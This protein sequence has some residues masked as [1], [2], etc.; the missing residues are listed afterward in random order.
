[1]RTNWRSYDYTAENATGPE[2]VKGYQQWVTQYTD[3]GWKPYE[4]SFMFN[5]LPG[6][7]RAI[8]EQMKQ[9]IYGINSKL[10]T[11]FHRDPRSPAAFEH[12][13]RMMLFPDLPVFKHAKK[14]IDDVALNDGLHYGGIALIP[15]VSRC[16]KDLK[17]LFANDLSKYVVGSLNRV[18]VEP[19]THTED[20]VT[21]YVMKTLKRGR[22]S[23]DDILVL[24]RTV[25]ELP[26]HP[27]RVPV[28]AAA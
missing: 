10:V 18:H 27:S 9:E 13:P 17:E 22:L 5:Q 14:G 11:R 4:V 1:V 8:L 3:E 21:D 7:Q 16:R 19:V 23:R 28:F 2:L 6:S 26:D 25:S 24:P 15:P 12:L 20:Y